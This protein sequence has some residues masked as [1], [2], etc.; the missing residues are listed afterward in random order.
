[1]FFGVS[2][3]VLSSPTP[4][5]ARLANGMPTWSCASVDGR[6]GYMISD[7]QLEWKA[8]MYIDES[9]TPASMVVRSWSR[10]VV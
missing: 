1:M 6:C 3:S 7:G 4:L 10:W 5:P 8:P 2:R 9:S